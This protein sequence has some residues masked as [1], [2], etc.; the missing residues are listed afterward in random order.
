MLGST[1]AGGQLLRRGLVLDFG[2]ADSI[3]LPNLICDSQHGGFVGEGQPMPVRAFNLG[4]PTVLR[5]HK[6]ASIFALTRE[7]AESSNAEAL[8]G[9]CAKRSLGL[10]LDQVLFDAVAGDAVRPSGLR[11]NVVASTAAGGGDSFEKM[12]ADIATL[13]GVVAPVG[14]PVVLV[15]SEAL[16]GDG[17]SK[18]AGRRAAGLVLGSPAIAPADLLAIAVD[19]LVTAIDPTIEVEA[20]RHGTIHIRRRPVAAR[21]S[22]PDCGCSAARAFP[23]GQHGITAE[24]RCDLGGAPPA[25]RELDVDDMVTTMDDDERCRIIEQARDTLQRTAWISVSDPPDDDDPLVRWAAGMPRPEPRRPA[26][27]RPAATTPAP[28]WSGWGKAR[29]AARLAEERKFLLPVVAQALGESLRRERAAAQAELADEV[30]RLRIEITAADETIAELRRTIAATDIRSGGSVIDL[31]A[32]R[33][34]N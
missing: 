18:I 22:G 26:K 33:G 14:G 3:S 15:A 5:P 24:T 20:G 16:C 28:D 13:L 23:D 27:R 25:G 4:T 6:S 19:A 12:L 2:R 29:L 10:A 8:I 7:M 9:E 32:R 31:P 30:K 11:F 17:A 34:V 21:L 1:G